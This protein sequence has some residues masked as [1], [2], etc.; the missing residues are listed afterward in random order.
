MIKK[1]MSVLAIGSILAF[2]SCNNTAPNTAKQI[3]KQLDSIRAVDSIARVEA[4]KQRLA[5]SIAN[6]VVVKTKKNHK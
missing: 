1:L 3:Q 2:V 6:I 4:E 5:D